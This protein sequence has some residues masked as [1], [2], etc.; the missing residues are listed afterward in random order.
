MHVSGVGGCGEV[1]DGIEVL[2]TGSHAVRNDL[3]ASEL[4]RVGSEH[5]LVGVECDPV[6][7]AE[8]KPVNCLEETG[9][10]V[11]CPEEGVIDALGLV[12]N[13][14][15][16]SHRIVMSSHHRKLCKP[17]VQFCSGIGPTG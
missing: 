12:R 4:N 8:V 14:G 16:L 17:E 5:E 6:A 3:K 11:I 13:M 2:C 15:D 10:K 7:P 1:T 9:C